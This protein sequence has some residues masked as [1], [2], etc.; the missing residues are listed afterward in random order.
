M[1]G[2][3]STGHFDI[4]P[5]RNK[6]QVTVDQDDVRVRTVL[7]SA[8]GS[9]ELTLPTRCCLSRTKQINGKKAIRSGHSIPLDR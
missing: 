6:E 5:A 4:Q 2:R 1:G 7:R 3:P 9:C 8:P